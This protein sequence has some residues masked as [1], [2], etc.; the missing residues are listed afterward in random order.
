MA[1]EPFFPGIITGLPAAELP[2]A[3]L[4]SH[5]FQG[6][7]QQ[8]IFME[9]DEDVAVPEHSHEAQWGVV[10]DGR[11]ELTIGGE[12]RVL[13]KGD[14]YFIPKSVPHSARIER[15]YK[16]LTLFDQR[17]RYRPEGNRDPSRKDLGARENEPMDLL[18][19]EVGPDDAEAIAGILNPIIESGAYSA[20]DTPFTV[21]DEGEFIGNFPPHG[22]FHLAEDSR[23]RGA[24]GFQTLEPYA[25]YTHAFDHVG[26]IATF[27][28]LGCR[29]RG[30]GGRLAE[31]TFE[32]ARGKGYEKIFTFVRA[33]NPDALQFYVKLGFQIVG[34]AGRQ[35][36]IGGKYVDEIL[37]ERFL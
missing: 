4:S 14:T 7:R 8:F 35:A 1:E 26:V 28:D 23:G 34:T 32:S 13:R 10:L 3:G 9:F 24:V 17:D 12:L 21:E 30:V 22:V 20:L 18:V 15:G 36:K 29:R 27:V 33:D 31:A 5:L 11:I 37:I 19:R 2:I 16:D 25:A 6:E